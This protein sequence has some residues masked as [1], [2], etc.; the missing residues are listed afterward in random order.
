MASG[1]E[2]ASAPASGPASE[3]ESGPESEP[4]SEPEG[5]PERDPKRVYRRS[6]AAGR[7]GFCG[8]RSCA[9]ATQRQRRRHIERK[10]PKTHRRALFEHGHGAHDKAQAAPLKQ[11]ST[12]NASRKGTAQATSP[13]NPSRK[14]PRTQPSRKRQPKRLP[15]ATKHRKR[16]PKRHHPDSRAPQT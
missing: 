2:P 4:E 15:Q 13:A 6:Q 11:P 9:A 14:H 16:Q 12:A 5:G 10:R 8:R 7:H 3:P 1:R